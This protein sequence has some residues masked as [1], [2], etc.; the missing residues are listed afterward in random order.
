MI[1][2]SMFK[3]KTHQFF[4]TQGAD[5]FQDRPEE[6]DSV[7]AAEAATSKSEAAFDAIACIGLLLGNG[8][9]HPRHS[10]QAGS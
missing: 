4:P 9:Q 5:L 2:S 10:F 3:R 6:R 8:R 7:L 1:R